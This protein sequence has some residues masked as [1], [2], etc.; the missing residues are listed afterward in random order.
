MLVI[1]FYFRQYR[2]GTVQCTCNDDL[3]HSLPVYSSN[4]SCVRLEELRKLNYSLDVEL[5]RERN[6][7]VT[8]QD[9]VMA[10]RNRHANQETITPAL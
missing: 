2:Y 4:L 10:P 5:Q 1:L 7:R 9:R 3:C 6:Q 8:M